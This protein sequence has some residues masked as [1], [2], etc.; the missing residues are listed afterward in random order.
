MSQD[1]NSTEE[2]RDIPGYEGYYQA[3]RHG[4]IK[5][6]SSGKI[7]KPSISNWGYYR[8]RLSCDGTIHY[9]SIH[10]LILLA[11][12]GY[13]NGSYEC[14][15]IDGNKSNNNIKNLEW[16]T[17]SENRLHS[18]RILGHRG[19]NMG[20]AKLSEAKVLEIRKLYL[21][22]EYS[23]EK[24]CHMFNV[25]VSLIGAII[26]NKA[27]T[28]VENKISV[29]GRI[30]IKQSTRSKKYGSDVS[31][32]KLAESDVITM[33]YMYKTGK[34]TQKEL[35]NMFGV[36]DRSVSGIINRKSWTHI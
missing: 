31:T 25:S 19:E 2:W 18:S 16:V 6:V 21:T 32:S 9:Q 33:R 15:H 26:T 36:N 7:L 27:W 8:V 17:S 20:A 35:G 5:R 11:F 3:S 29:N 13:A 24:L 22:G 28:H 4:R 34:Y 12:A 30:A 14:N 1:Y 10:R 23:Y